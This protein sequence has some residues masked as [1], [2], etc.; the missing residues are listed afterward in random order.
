[1]ESSGGNPNF[2][3]VAKTQSDRDK[4][5]FFRHAVPESVNMLIDRRKK[6]DPVIT[7][8]GSDMSVP[9]EHLKDVMSVYA[10]TLKDS[11]LEYASWGNIGDNHIHVNILPRN[12][13]DYKKGKALF[14]KWAAIV[15]EMGGAVSAEHG[16]GKLKA[17]F[18]TIMYGENHIDEMADLK[19]SLDPKGLFGRGN[20][21]SLDERGI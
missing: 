17:P 14:E 1:M 6:E 7:K 19:L 4:L 21:F 5:Q 20:M 2:T 18:L 9:N 12:G 3:W 13:E 8:L 10:E 11:G 15:T 16:V